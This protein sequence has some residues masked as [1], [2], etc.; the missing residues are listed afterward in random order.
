MRI[1]PYDQ[2]YLGSAPL[3]FEIVVIILKFNQDDLTSTSFSYHNRTIN[4]NQPLLAASLVSST[5]RWAAQSILYACPVITEEMGLDLLLRSIEE[6][7]ELTEEVTGLRMSDK[8]SETEGSLCFDSSW[9]LATFLRSC[10]NVR[11]IWLENVWFKLEHLKVCQSTFGT[12][13]LR[14]RHS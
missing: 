5:W 1:D 13:I 8:I 3:P 11:E 6:R 14:R 10:V 7:N 9:K 4:P 2:P 12:S